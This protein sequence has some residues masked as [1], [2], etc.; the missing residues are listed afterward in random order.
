[1]LNGE[2]FGLPIP[3]AGPVFAT[4]LV[5]HV[6]SGLLLSSLE[7]SPRPPA[8]DPD[9]TPVRRTEKNDHHRNVPDQM[10]C[11]VRAANADQHG[12]ELWTVTSVQ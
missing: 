8:N 11:L 6:L 5:L 2:I 4:A 3:D 12:A 1:M 10:A 7:R 9:V